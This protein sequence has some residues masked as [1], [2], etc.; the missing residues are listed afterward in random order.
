METP[1]PEGA[2]AGSPANEAL[3]ELNGLVSQVAAE[4]GATTGATAAD[5]KPPEP[6]RRPG[7]PPVH[8]LYSKAAGSDGKHPVPPPGQ[9]TGP[10]GDGSVGIDLLE[11]LPEDIVTEVIHEGIV[12]GE[13]ALQHAIE[14]K[15]TLAGLNQSQI[16]AQLK[17]AQVSPKKK[18]LVA[19]LTPYAA[20]ELGMELKM[21]P[22]AAILFLLAPTALAGASAYLT[23]AKLAKEAHAKGFH[24]ENNSSHR[25]ISQRDPEQ[26]KGAPPTI[27]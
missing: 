27:T 6:G 9:E 25:G 12:T 3:T 4:H 5:A 10:E 17:A 22:V 11:A 8:G 1:L 16:V 15:A 19:R 13:S 21:S 24:G 26:P 20:K 23:M 7:R 18:E 14:G 2:E